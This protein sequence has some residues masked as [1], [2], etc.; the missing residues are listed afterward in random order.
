MSLSL[1]QDVGTIARSVLTILLDP[2]AKKV[3]QM[4]ALKTAARFT[5]NAIADRYPLSSSRLK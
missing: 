4:A 3:L 5:P 2:H 1:L